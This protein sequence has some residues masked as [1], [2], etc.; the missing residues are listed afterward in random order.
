ME[1]QDI[2][3][4]R[5][6]GNIYLPETLRFKADRSVNWSA[7]EIS[8]GHLEYSRKKKL[9]GRDGAGAGSLHALVSLQYKYASFNEEKEY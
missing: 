5:T 7:V 9:Q 3:P 8:K 4:V 2:H 6:I 1:C